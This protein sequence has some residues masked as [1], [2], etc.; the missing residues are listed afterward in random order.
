MRGS[1]ARVQLTPVFFAIEHVALRN[2]NRRLEIQLPGERARIEAGGEVN[3]QRIFVVLLPDI[4]DA[5][6][7]RLEQ[8]ECR[9]QVRADFLLGGLIQMQSKPPPPPADDDEHK[10]DGDD[11]AGDFEKLAYQWG[12]LRMVV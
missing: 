11:H 10:D 1:S 7:A 4:D 5:M 3:F 9:P 12:H 6:A 2:V 8:L